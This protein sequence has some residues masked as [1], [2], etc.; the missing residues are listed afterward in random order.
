MYMYVYTAE[1]ANRKATSTTHKG[2]KRQLGAL[3]VQSVASSFSSLK[4][5]HSGL[6]VGRSRREGPTYL[7]PRPASTPIQ[8]ADTPSDRRR[9]VRSRRLSRILHLPKSMVGI[10]LTAELLGVSGGHGSMV[11]YNK[12]FS[13]MNGR[14]ANLACLADMQAAAALGRAWSDFVLWRAVSKRNRASL[15]SR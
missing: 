4:L 5:L 12:R 7:L 3:G 8:A 9:R 13:A 10:T 14:N 2:Q 15:Y 11:G 1:S 6:P